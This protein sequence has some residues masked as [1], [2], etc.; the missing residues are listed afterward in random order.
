MEWDRNAL[1]GLTYSYTYGPIHA[2]AAPDRKERH[3]Q[4]PVPSRYDTELDNT[5]GHVGWSE[6]GRGGCWNKRRRIRSF[7]LRFMNF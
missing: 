5:S 1:K 4:M 7:T 3:K 2:V 6:M